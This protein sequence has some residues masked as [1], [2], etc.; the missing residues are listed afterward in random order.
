MSYKEFTPHQKQSRPWL[1]ST[2]AQ[3][4][5]VADL[6]P[7]SELRQDS[8]MKPI[9]HFPSQKFLSLQGRWW[10]WA[11]PGPRSL[12]PHKPGLESWLIFWFTILATRD[13]CLSLLCL[14]HSLTERINWCSSWHRLEAHCPWFPRL[15][16]PLSSAP[17]SPHSLPWKR[18]FERYCI[19]KISEKLLSERKLASSFVLWHLGLW[20]LSVTHQGVS[21]VKQEHIETPWSPLPRSTPNL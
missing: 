4:F 5:S 3:A 10:C 7:H 1:L 17:I 18:L 16:H 12:A 6:T 11:V 20:G 8:V 9:S 19:R 15:P 21:V 13:T 14:F 2:S